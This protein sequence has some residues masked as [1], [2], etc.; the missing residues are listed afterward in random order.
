MDK[1]KYTEAELLELKM[2]YL[3][4]SHEGQEDEI[5]VFDEMDR[6]NSWI[7]QAVLLLDGGQGVGGGATSRYFGWVHS[8]ADLGGSFVLHGAF[9]Y[10]SSMAIQPIAENRARF[11]A[12][13]KALLPFD[14]IS[15][16]DIEVTSSPRTIRISK[17]GPEIRE[18]FVELVKKHVFPPPQIEVAS[19]NAPLPP[20]PNGR[21]S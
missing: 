7:D 2:P 5:I 4:L 19:P 11:I 9:S 1:K 3:K 15:Q 6:T 14:M 13:P 17:Q 20:P 12:G 18:T 16:A 8:K 10:I 21:K